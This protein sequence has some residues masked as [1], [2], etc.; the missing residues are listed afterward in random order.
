MSSG[1][2]PQSATNNNQCT[3]TVPVQ[4]KMLILLSVPRNKL[5]KFQCDIR[6]KGWKIS[7]KELQSKVY[8]CPNEKKDQK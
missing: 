3:D 6:E 7:M 4:S 1:D 2:S 5:E 8:V